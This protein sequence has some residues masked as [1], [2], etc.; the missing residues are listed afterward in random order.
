MFRVGSL[1]EMGPPPCF[2]DKETEAQRYKLTH[3]ALLYLSCLIAVLSNY[4]FST[5]SSHLFC[6]GF[7]KGKLSLGKLFGLQLQ[8]QPP[9]R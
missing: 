8:T 6:P 7:T 3:P 2:T 1:G 4:M 9:L 5:I